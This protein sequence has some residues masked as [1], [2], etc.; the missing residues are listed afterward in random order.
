M[1]LDKDRLIKL[2]NMTMSQHDGEALSAI[3]KSNELLLLN[4]TSWSDLFGGPSSPGMRPG[5]DRGTAWMPEQDAARTQATEGQIESGRMLL[6]PIRAAARFYARY[7]IPRRAMV[8]RGIA[9][10][11]AVFVLLLCFWL[12][13]VTILEA[14]G[15]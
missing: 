15:L 9:R 10:F 5:H 3:R 12:S 13:V 7:L 1:P 8:A 6:A 11:I 14:F 2:L 4:Q